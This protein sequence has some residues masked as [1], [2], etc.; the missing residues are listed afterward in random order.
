MASRLSLM[1]PQGRG[2]KREIGVREL[3][4]E[5]SRYVERAASGAEIVVTVRGRQVA[6]LLPMGAEDPLADLRRRGLVQEPTRTKRRARGRAR[7]KPAAPVAELVGE[8]RRP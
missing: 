2:H 7:P 3:R 6:R 8:Q 4:D 5:L 1:T